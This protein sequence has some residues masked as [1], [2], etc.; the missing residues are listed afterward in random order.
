[1]SPAGQS[2]ASFYKIR[3]NLCVAK[4][5]HKSAE[6][7]SLIS[8]SPPAG[9]GSAVSSLLYEFISLIYEPPNK[10]GLSQFTLVFSVLDGGGKSY[11]FLGG[12]Y[13]FF[14]TFSCNEIYSRVGIKSL[15]LL[16]PSN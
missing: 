13:T 16:F 9:A 10:D 6:L 7:I 11:F 8:G 12:L 14:L 2:C 5:D 1:M 4:F 3:G 15:Q